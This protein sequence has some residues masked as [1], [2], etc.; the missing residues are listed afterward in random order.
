MPYPTAAAPE[1]ADG[2]LVLFRFSY[3]SMPCRVVAGEAAVTLHAQMGIMPFTGDGPALRSRM[4]AVLGGA[5]RK[6]S[7]G[8]LLTPDHGVGLTVMLPVDGRAPPA[9]I[10]AAAI[11]G[12]AEA[13]PLLDAVHSLLPTHLRH[14]PQNPRSD[15]YR[16]AD[17]GT[18]KT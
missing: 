2:S 9:S 16:M 17:S 11:G 18:A 8:V 13:K 12:L 14:R 5:R 4:L 3:R 6:P 15:A 7:Y 10:L 1:Q